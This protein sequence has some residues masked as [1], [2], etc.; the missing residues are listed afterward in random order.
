MRLHATFTLSL[1]LSKCPF[2]CV[3]HT[4][5]IGSVTC[6]DVQDHR[7]IHSLA[8]NQITRVYNYVHPEFIAKTTDMSLE[9]WVLME[10]YDLN[11]LPDVD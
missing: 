1:R 4:K 8:I 6:T 9:I 3:P 7:S 10:Y 5:A 2:S 11:G